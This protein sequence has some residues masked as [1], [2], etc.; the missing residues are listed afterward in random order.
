VLA[1][2]SAAAYCS[3]VVLL[4]FPKENTSVLLDQSKQTEHLPFEKKNDRK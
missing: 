1:V 2:S 4:Y 3:F